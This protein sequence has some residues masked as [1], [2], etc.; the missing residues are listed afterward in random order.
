[1]R[2]RYAISKKIDANYYG[3][4]DY[5][6][7]ILE[8]VEQPVEKDMWVRVIREWKMIEFI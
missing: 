5:E 1:M 2:S 3:Y 8:K 6:N 4:K 7:D